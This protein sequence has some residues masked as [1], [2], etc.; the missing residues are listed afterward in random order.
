MALSRSTGLERYLQAHGAVRSLLVAVGLQLRS[1]RSAF[2]MFRGHCALLFYMTHGYGSSQPCK[3][4]PPTP[5]WLT[6]DDLEAMEKLA[7]ESGGRTATC[8]SINLAL[9]RFELVP[10]KEGFLEPCSRETWADYAEACPARGIRFGRRAEGVAYT[11]S[12]STMRIF[13]DEEAVKAKVSQLLG[14]HPSGCVVLFAVD[15]DD[16]AAR[17][18]ARGP[19]PRVRA[20]AELLGRPAGETF[21]PP[22]DVR[23]KRALVCVVTSNMSP[24][25][26]LT[27][28]CT[29]LVLWG[30]LYHAESGTFSTPG[31]SVREL[32][33]EPGCPIQLLLGV[34]PSIHKFLDAADE[35][36]L[37]QLVRNVS[38]WLAGRHLHGV[39]LFSTA[40]GS[41]IKL[42]LLSTK[43]R[44]YFGAAST[45]NLTVA[46]GLEYFYAADSLELFGRQ[47]DLLFYVTHR[48]KSRDPCTISQPTSYWPSREDLLAT[49]KLADDSHGKTATCISINLAVLSF[50][51]LPAKDKFYDACSKE[52][53]T[54][55]N[56][57]CQVAGEPSGRESGVAVRK[58]A[59]TMQVFED[60]QTVKD[61]VSQFLS[62]LPTGC[63]VLFAADKDDLSG[64]CSAGKP[65]PRVQ[66]VSELLALETK[67]KRE[68]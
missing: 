55:Y 11:R 61:K 56:Q 27:Q 1:S 30:A 47:C 40:F 6:Q 17:C 52:A 50:Q 2:N 62:I 68:R 63:V 13:E 7:D 66:A 15:K 38:K 31:A 12:A 44:T 46:V 4:S 22:V 23:D 19:L 49:K 18:A 34:H 14:A 45:T 59:T 5:D 24:K 60:E 29:H 57:T 65:A 43:L 8:V 41:P 48:Y 64:R 25:S 28:L 42:L 3:L 9:M 26:A 32:Q 36:A 54:D 67:L 10:G 21:L 35:S 37:T 51:L 16:E 39:A 20:A 33:L 53:W 58:S